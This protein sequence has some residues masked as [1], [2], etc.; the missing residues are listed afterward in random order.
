MLLKGVDDDVVTTSQIANS[1]SAKC[2]PEF[3]GRRIYDA[4]LARYLRANYQLLLTLTMLLL[5]KYIAA[6]FVCDMP[7]YTRWTRLFDA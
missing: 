7:F 1:R 5:P 6:S 2:S 4:C 3:E